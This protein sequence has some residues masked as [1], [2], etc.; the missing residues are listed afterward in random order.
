[1][2]SASKFESGSL[3]ARTVRFSELVPCKTAFIDSRTPG[4]DRKENFC[5]IGGGVSENPGQHVHIRSPHRFDIGAARQ[6]GGCKN[7]HHSHDTEEVFVVHRGSWKFTW[8][9]KGEDG[10]AVLDA[11]DTISIPVQVFRGFENV[12]ADD[13]FLFSILGLQADGSAGHVTWAPQVF[14]DARNH[15]LVLLQDGKLIDTAAGQEIPPNGI[16]C[17]GPDPEQLKQFRTMSR[18]E[19]LCC[20]AFDRDLTGSSR[21]APREGLQGGLNCFPGVEEIPVAG[22]AN[23]GESLPMGKLGWEHG[24]QLRRL[25]MRP[26]S[27]VPAHR[28][29]EE[30]VIFIHRGGM[31]VSVDGET[32]RLGTGDLLT[33]PPAALRKSG[34]PGA[35]P[36]DA[37]LVRG[38][39]FPGKVELV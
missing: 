19:M 8:G 2:Q 15:G 5:I 24:F 33:V 11:G 4:S 32:T 13:G 17:S 16:V 28:R 10:E 12:G 37:I 25:R 20:I 26:G 35:E 29:Q 34:N 39:N 7:S 21:D 18:Q 31:E 30:E 27:E 23:P 36:L 1:M 6:P 14:K 38:G 9:E 3:G 22:C